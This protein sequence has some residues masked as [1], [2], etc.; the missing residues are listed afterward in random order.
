MLEAV[1]E[2]RLEEEIRSKEDPHERQ[3][4]FRTGRSTISAMKEVMDTMRPATNK[5]AQ[6]KKF[7]VLV[8]IDV[9]N[10]FNVARWSGILADMERR[11]IDRYLIEMVRSCLT[12]RTL[13]VG[14][15]SRMRLNCGVPQGSVLGPL[16]W[17][18]YDDDV[19]RVEMPDGVTL[20]GYDLALVAVAK[21]GTQLRHKINTA[22]VDLMEW[23]KRKNYV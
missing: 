13:I 6:H 23:L 3:H 9:R 11:D 16:P 14:E 2:E 15:R 17:N 21:S 8:T 7:C 22:S 1:A 20:I 12:N 4:G 10:A 5:A 18:L 19:F